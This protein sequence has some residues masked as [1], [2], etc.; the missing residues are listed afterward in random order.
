MV[1]P[2]D[3]P[4]MSIADAALGAATRRRLAEDA[5]AVDG[6][7]RMV[8]ARQGDPVDDLLLLLAGRAM[9][10]RRFH[11]EDVPVAELTPG[12]LIGLEGVCGTGRHGLTVQALGPV[13]YAV[14]PRRDFMARVHADPEAA[15]LAFTVLAGRLR[16]CIKSTDALKFHDATARV[17]RYLLDRL[18]GAPTVGEASG[19]LL[20]PKK[21]LAAHLGITQ[22]S[23]SRVLRQLRDEGVVMRGRVIHVDDVGRLIDLIADEDVA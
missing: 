23:L 22:Q 8:L 18:D 10:L 6:K 3:E 4:S 16:A 11:G 21:I 17:A 7:D 19:R 5:P 1:L 13:R 2:P 20:F 15:L 12:V 14:L 9:A